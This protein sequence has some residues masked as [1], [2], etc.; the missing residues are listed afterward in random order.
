M[1]ISTLSDERLTE[2]AGLTFM[3][4]L[5]LGVSLFSE[6]DIDGQTVYLAEGDVQI[7]SSDGTIDVIISAGTDKSKFPLDDSQPR[8]VSCI[9]ISENNRFVLS[10]SGDKTAVLWLKKWTQGGRHLSSLPRPMSSLLCRPFALL[11]AIQFIRSR[12]KRLAT[13]LVMT[14]YR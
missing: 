7:K 11:R 13:I 8:Q 6:G 3:E 10:G 2:L 4:S 12:P 14:P 1:P 5:N 9:A